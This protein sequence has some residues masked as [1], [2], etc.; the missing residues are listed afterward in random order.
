MEKLEYVNI[1][2][3]VDVAWYSRMC[4]TIFPIPA[5]VHHYISDPR[6]AP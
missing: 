3:I 4:I 1:C 2:K 6:A 5:H